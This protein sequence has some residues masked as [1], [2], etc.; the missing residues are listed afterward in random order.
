MAT[1]TRALKVKLAYE[2]ATSRTYTFNGIDG[3]GAMGAKPK[4][5]AL[6]ASLE[7]GTANYFKNVFVSENGSPCKMI[8][9]VRVIVTT[10]DIIYQAS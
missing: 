2:D 6:N 5:I 3:Q 1:T 8:S 4:A 9:D 10:Q 7:A